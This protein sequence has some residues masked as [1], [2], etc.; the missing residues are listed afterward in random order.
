MARYK[1]ADFE[2]AIPGSGGIISTI[3]EK[4]GCDWHTVKAWLD[5][6][7]DLH[8]MW[9][10]ER[11]QRNDAAKSVYLSNIDSLHRIQTHARQQ[12]QYWGQQMKTPG[13]DIEQYEEAQHQYLYWL[14]KATVDLGDVRWW[15]RMMDDDFKEQLDLN[16]NQPLI[17]V[18]VDY[19]DYITE[20][21]PRPVRDSDPPGQV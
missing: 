19:R 4:V 15:L 5:R 17:G 8:T 16:V 20:L 18:K 14:D 11:Y 9:E 3:A 13:I 1:K 7:P 12:A 21:A 10:A 6:S 2:A